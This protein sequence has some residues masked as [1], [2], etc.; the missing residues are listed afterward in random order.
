MHSVFRIGVV[1]QMDKN[2]RLWQVELT[3]TSDNDQQL[4]AL[5]ERKRQDASGSPGWRRLADL[6][7]KLGESDKAKELI[8]AQL[9]RAGDGN[10]K[11]AIFNRLGLIAEEQGRYE[12]AITI[13]GKALEIVQKTL[14]AN[15]PSLA[16]SYNSM[17]SVY[18][19][20]GEYSKALSYHQKALEL[21]QK[22]L[23]EN[24]SDLAT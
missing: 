22:T 2:N 11:G 24:Q 4:H 16:T 6:L 7:F 13:H 14:P 3:L 1:M 20:M 8:E 17:G 10:Q 18:S 9:K 15:H 19:K 21:I 23:H 12:E 5:T